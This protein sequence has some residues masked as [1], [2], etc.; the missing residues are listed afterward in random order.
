MPVMQFPVRWTHQA[1]LPKLGTSVRPLVA[2]ASQGTLTV[3]P[4]ALEI[5]SL[6]AGRYLTNTQRQSL[7]A[8]AH[9]FITDTTLGPMGTGGLS[10]VDVLGA[11]FGMIQFSLRNPA[12]WWFVRIPEGKGASP[13]IYALADPGASPWNVELKGVAPCHGELKRGDPLDTCDRIMTQRRKGLAQLSHPVLQVPQASAIPFPTGGAIPPALLAGG[14]ALCVTVLPHAAL[15]HRS[16]IPKLTFKACPQ[17]GRCIDSCLRSSPSAASA[18]LVGVLWQEA[19]AAA[20]GGSAGSPIATTG[21]SAATDLL[22][23][24]AAASAG[25]WASASAIV[26][27]GLRRVFVRAGELLDPNGALALM[28]RALVCYQLSSSEAVRAEFLRHVDGL[29]RRDEEASGDALHDELAGAVEVPAAPTLPIVEG[30]RLDDDQLP[31]RGIQHV[32]Q[33]GDFEW[34]GTWVGR[35]FRLA[36]RLTS[37]QAAFGRNQLEQVRA[38]ATQAFNAVASQVRLAERTKSDLRGYPIRISVSGAFRREV[39]WDVGTAF[40]DAGT[41]DPSWIAYDGRIQVAF[42][43][44]A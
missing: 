1:R 7:G 26:D 16:D 22:L 15:V 34:A 3:H 9:E 14:R 35:Y 10:Q 25:A 32:V 4:L 6:V 31:E 2:K 37:L 19:N 33:L 38:A 20:S 28:R 29:D 30:L 41:H 44:R 36:P 21:V 18:S 17:G 23:A 11:I 43:P 5:L 39:S 8:V 40:G 24:F 12:P 42:P 13:D 27:E